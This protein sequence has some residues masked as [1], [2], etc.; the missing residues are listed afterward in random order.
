MFIFIS[1]LILVIIALSAVIYFLLSR[2]ISH[3]HLNVIV[4]A[5]ESCSE[6]ITLKAYFESIADKNKKN[7][8]VLGLSLP[9][10]WKNF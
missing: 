3:V 8:T 5:L 4:Q 10:T 2:K 1:I 9:G 7:E 6:M